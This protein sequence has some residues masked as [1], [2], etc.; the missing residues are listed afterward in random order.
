MLTYLLHSTNASFNT[1]RMLM[2]S[3]RKAQV[4]P[5]PNCTKPDAVSCCTIFKIKRFDITLHYNCFHFK[6][7]KMVI[8]SIILWLLCSTPKWQH[9]L[10]E[11]NESNKKNALKGLFSF[12]K[13]AW[14]NTIIMFTQC[15]YCFSICKLN[16]IV[17][18]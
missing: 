15:Y 12:Q 2:L 5:D 1:C 17:L 4:Q 3:H 14:F 11:V 10:K 9:C 6:M 18:Q 7:K 16:N 8:T 13:G